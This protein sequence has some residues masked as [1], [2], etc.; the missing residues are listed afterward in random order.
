M[1]PSNL[2][3]FTTAY[4]VCALWSSTGDDDEP[5]DQEHGITDFSPE[6]LDQAVKECAAFQAE[7]QATLLLA[8][9]EESRAGHCFWLSR[10]GHGSGF[11]DE[12]SINACHEVARSIE[13]LE[14]DLD[15]TC[16]CPYH[17]CQR[18]QEA[19]QKAGNRDLYEGDD[20]R[21]YFA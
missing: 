17:A 20:Q 9:L 5:L 21:L 11:F 7:N 4:L 16:N 8:E 2:D 6:A 15:K 18:L 3:S 19:A 14:E 10:N 13:A 1:N 12:C